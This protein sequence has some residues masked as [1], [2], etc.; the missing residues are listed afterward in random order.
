MSLINL[1][2]WWVSC[3]WAYVVCWSLMV[4]TQ[5]DEVQSVQVWVRVMILPTET[6]LLYILMPTFPS[7]L[8][9]CWFSQCF[10]Q[11]QSSVM[12]IGCEW[13]SCSWSTM[14][15]IQTNRW[16]GPFTGLLSLIWCATTREISSLL[17][18]LGVICGGNM[19]GK[20]LPE[21]GEVCPFNNTV[22]RC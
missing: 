6:S 12:T 8:M 22:G 20:R 15:P 17:Y 19:E 3:I 9:W 5:S 18:R 16:E 14:A 2:Y 10:G 1:F 7:I 11:S 13:I 21:G 4:N